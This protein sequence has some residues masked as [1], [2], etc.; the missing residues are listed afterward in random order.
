MLFD[1]ALTSAHH[2]VPG[3]VGVA[4]VDIPTGMLL[5]VATVDPA[6]AEHLD[7]AA[8]AVADLFDG[9]IVSAIQRMLGPIDTDAEAA[10]EHIVLLRQDLL[11]VL[12]RGRRY[13]DHAAIF[14]CR[15]AFEVRSVLICVSDALARIEAAF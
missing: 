7:D 12:T 10:A 4:Y 15:S 14:V 9:P 6:K 2:D 8:T 5:G 11:H 1:N 3:C 13:P